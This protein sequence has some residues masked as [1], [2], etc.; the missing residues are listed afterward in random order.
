MRRG[1][2]LLTLFFSTCCT[3]VFSQQPV[4]PYDAPSKEE[5]MNFFEVMHVREHIDVIMKA[6]MVQVRQNVSAAIAKTDP[7]LS[8]EN[9]KKMDALVADIYNDIQKEFATDEMLEDIVPVYQRHLT[10]A[11][12]QAV[13]DFYQSPA[14]QR[15]LKESPAMS[16]EAMQITNARSQKLMEDIMAKTKQ[17]VDAMKAAGEQQ[18]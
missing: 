4:L 13:V 1:L 11:D 10:R 8:V 14:G 9:T 15:L 18:K 7:N 12:L 16:V 2:I 17:R 6:A 3:T 5:V